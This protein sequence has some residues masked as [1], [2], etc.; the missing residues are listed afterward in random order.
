LNILDRARSLLQGI[1]PTAPATV[2]YFSVACPEG[3]RLRGAR[4]EGYQAS[5]CP[6]CGERIFVLSRSPLPELSGPA[7]AWPSHRNLPVEGST[8]GPDAEGRFLLAGQYESML[9]DQAT[10]TELL[11]A[12]W[13]IDPQSKA[14]ADAFRRRGF[15]KVNEEWV[16]PPRSHDAVAAADEPSVSALL[17]DVTLRNKSPREVR[18]RLGGKPN[19][20]AWSASQGQLIEQWIDLGPTL[21]QY[22]NFLHTPGVPVPRVV[23]DYTRPR[24]ASEPLS[25]PRPIWPSPPKF[26]SCMH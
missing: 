4:T 21:N 24:A 5:R 11:R 16:K 17:A 13:K 7:P 8:V 20:V 12:A 18:A 3:H 23:A 15:R 1:T 26:H 25:T 19:R 6:K 2:H 9:G 14:V 10:A 22:V